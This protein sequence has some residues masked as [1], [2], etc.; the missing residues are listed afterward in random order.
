MSRLML[1]TTT[2][3]CGISLALL[4]CETPPAVGPTDPG[5]S[6]EAGLSVPAFSAS[7]FNGT[8]RAM[9]SLQPARWRHAADVLGKSIVVVGGLRGDELHALSRVDAFNVETRTWTGLADLPVPLYEANGAT[10]INGSKLYVTGGRSGP[11]DSPLKSLYMY[12]PSTNSWSR[13]ADMPLRGALGVQANI[14][15]KLYVYTHTQ[16]PADPHLF[17]SYNPK[18]NKWERLPSP[19]HGHFAYPVAGAINGK[20]YLTSGQGE[21]FADRTLE[22]YDPATRTWAIK[23]PMP[24]ARAVASAAVVHGK[25]FVAGG[26]VDRNG[27]AASTDVVEAYDPLSDTWATGPSLPTAR[28]HAVAVW[29]GGKFFVIDGIADGS[30]SSRVEALSTTY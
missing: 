20:F 22:V 28:G 24:T 17:A 27:V 29:A 7:T 5:I 26:V 30:L 14:E 1:R 12:D 11:N 25:L 3:L 19:K 8:W 6:V 21:P 18:T 10:T 16:S 4:A 13:K 15:G 9:P 23:S 2:T